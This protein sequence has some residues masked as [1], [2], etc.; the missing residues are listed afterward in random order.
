MIVVELS[1]SGGKQVSQ[2]K[3]CCHCKT[4]EN[5]EE[6]YLHIHPMVVLF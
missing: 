3:T 5:Q 4:H 6:H 1:V 2:Q